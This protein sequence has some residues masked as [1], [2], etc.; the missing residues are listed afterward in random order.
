MYCELCGS[1]MQW[2]STNQLNNVAK[3]KCPRC[4]N[5]QSGLD[6]YEPIVKEKFTPKHY[7]FH[8]GRFVV[9]KVIDGKH[10]YIGAFGNEE[11]AKKVVDKMD[12]YGWDKSMRRQVYE[13][14]GMH[15]VNNAWV[16]A[17]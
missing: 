9:R 6:D 2:R 11:T 14:L 12:E 3:F 5:V 7:Y 8:D 15:R 13:E 10:R 4:G 17:V 16:C 1:S